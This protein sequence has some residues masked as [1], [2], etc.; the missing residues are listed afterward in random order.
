MKLYF[1]T[2]EAAEQYAKINYAKCL[3]KKSSTSEFNGECFALRVI[4]VDDLAIENW[5][6]NY[7]TEV[8]V[9]VA[10]EAAFYH[11]DISARGEDDTPTY[12]ILSDYGELIDTEMEGTCQLYRFGGR[13]WVVLA[14]NTVISKEE[15]DVEDPIFPDAY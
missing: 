11:A 2:Q 7:V 13:Y 6:R 15:D 14:D 5:N 10:D 3:V 8:A 4:E 1:K 9:L 12:D